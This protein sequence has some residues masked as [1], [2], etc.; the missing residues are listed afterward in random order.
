MGMWQGVEL[1]ELPN[2]NHSRTL[3]G[4]L[5]PLLLTD[6]SVDSAE[7]HGSLGGCGSLSQVLHDQGS[8]AEDIDKL[9]QVG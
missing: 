5:K 4:I 3:Q 1:D 6:H 8:V 7:E 9:S 2:S